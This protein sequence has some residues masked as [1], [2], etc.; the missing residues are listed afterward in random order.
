MRRVK[1]SGG[2]WG[3]TLRQYCVNCITVHLHVLYSC[4]TKKILFLF[5]LFY[6]FTSFSLK[7][8]AGQ[9]CSNYL[10]LLYKDFWSFLSVFNFLLN[11]YVK[12]TQSQIPSTVHLLSLHI[13]NTHTTYK[14]M[15]TFHCFTTKYRRGITQSTFSV[16]SMRKLV[17]CIIGVSRVLKMKVQESTLSPL[18]PF[19]YPA[20]TSLLAF[21]ILVTS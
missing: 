7:N 16:P 17:F 1:M 10:M 21:P 5:V 11:L 14:Y 19:C 2:S 9:E 12:P 8:D 13:K 20:A 4:F 18:L 3:R 15:E 6:F